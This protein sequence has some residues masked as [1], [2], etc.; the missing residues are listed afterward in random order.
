MAAATEPDDSVEDSLSNDSEGFVVRATLCILKQILLWTYLYVYVYICVYVDETYTGWSHRCPC[1]SASAKLYRSIS[2]SSGCFIHD[3]VHAAI[4]ASHSNEGA[5][6]LSLAYRH[7]G[8]KLSLPI[9]ACLLV[10]HCC[11]TCRSRWWCGLSADVFGVLEPTADIGCQPQLQLSWWGGRNQPSHGS[12]DQSVHNHTGRWCVA[13]I[14]HWSLPLPTDLYHY[15]LISNRI[16]LA[17]NLAGRRSQ[18]TCPSC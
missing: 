6:A 18:S 5:T 4:H 13:F 16:Y 9:S 10:R 8:P 14:I 1:V 15:P 17:M 3:R 12:D 7:L 2:Q 11:I